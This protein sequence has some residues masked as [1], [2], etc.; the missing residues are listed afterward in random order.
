[1]L[2]HPVR[3]NVVKQA[4]PASRRQFLNVFIFSLAKGGVGE[5]YAFRARTN[6]KPADVKAH[7]P[8]KSR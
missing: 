1:M 5:A 8:F 4:M 2:L 3:P 7:R 6:E